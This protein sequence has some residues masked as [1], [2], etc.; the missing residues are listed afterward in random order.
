MK[1]QV[2]YR[3]GRDGRT[4]KT[5]FNPSLYNNATTDAE[6]PIFTTCLES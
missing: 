2:D 4:D 5:F 6:T 3:T 1:I